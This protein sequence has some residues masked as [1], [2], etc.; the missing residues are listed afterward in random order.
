MNPVRRVKD[1]FEDTPLASL[2]FRDRLPVEAFERGLASH[3]PLPVSPGVRFCHRAEK[4]IFL[5]GCVVSTVWDE[6]K[7]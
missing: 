1:D 4:N 3:F 6:S 2:D 5:K 7:V